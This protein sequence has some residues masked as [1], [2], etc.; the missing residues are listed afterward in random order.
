MSFALGSRSP[1][2]ETSPETSAAGSPNICGPWALKSTPEQGGEVALAS[3]GS[4][5]TRL[6]AL[7][8]ITATGFSSYRPSGSV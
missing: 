4:R 5:T 8:Q 7:L 6:F 1:L 2:E 3:W